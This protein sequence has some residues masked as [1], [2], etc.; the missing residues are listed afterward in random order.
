M[1][2]LNSLWII[3]L[4]LFIAGCNQTTNKEATIET[5]E[6]GVAVL[7][8]EQIEDIIKRSYQYVAM[9]NVNNK[10]AMLYGGWN[11]VDVDDQPKDHTL[12]VIARPNND[13]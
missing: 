4:A 8:D 6:N 9:Y 2:K 7:S 5:D 1:K 13:T 3:L 10:G 11:V 12:K